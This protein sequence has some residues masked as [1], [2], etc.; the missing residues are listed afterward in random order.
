MFIKKWA[1]IA[2]TPLLLAC[3]DS[4]SNSPTGTSAST[5]EGLR[6]PAAT[7]MLVF[8][9]WYV[10]LI[11]LSKDTKHL[12]LRVRCAPGVVRRTDDHDPTHGTIHTILHRVVVPTAAQIR[13]ELPHA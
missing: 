6:A 4:W 3:S 7:T 2:C 8:R 9:L 1:R 10:S 11:V 5:E 12:T 13:G